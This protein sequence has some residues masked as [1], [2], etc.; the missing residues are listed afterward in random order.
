MDILRRFND[1]KE[2]KALLLD[3]LTDYFQEKIIG[4]AM[5]KESVESL[6]DAIKELELG[7]SQLDIDYAIKQDKVV[8]NSSR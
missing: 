3:Y 7:F 8:E 1:D 6:A 5:K 4:R 2:L